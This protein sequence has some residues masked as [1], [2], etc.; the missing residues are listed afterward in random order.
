[1]AKFNFDISDDFLKELGSMAEVDKY[2]PQM[3]EEALPILEQKVKQETAKH[4]KTGDMY[5]SIKKTKV[6]KSKYDGYYATV[7]PTGTDSKGVRNMEKMVYL[8][9]G[10]SDQ[11]ATPVLTKAV[12]DSEDEV[13]EKMQEV[14]NRE[15]GME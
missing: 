4:K 11:P 15:V 14:F 1:M 13:L 5:K 2:A 10:T 3:I 9:Y 7:R 6:S 8:E 12:N